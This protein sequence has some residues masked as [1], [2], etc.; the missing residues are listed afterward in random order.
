MWGGLQP[1]FSLLA[2]FS[3]HFEALETFEVLGG[4]KPRLKPAAG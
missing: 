1:G 3:P 2:G 4:L